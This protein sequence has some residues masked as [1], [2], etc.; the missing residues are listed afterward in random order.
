MS[1][2]IKSII[3]KVLFGTG[4]MFSLCL[5]Q[6]TLAAAQSPLADDSQLAVSANLWGNAGSIAPL[7]RAFDAKMAPLASSKPTAPI[8]FNPEYVTPGGLT[9]GARID[10]GSA[11]QYDTQTALRALVPQGRNRS[12]VDK[13]Y[14]YADGS[15]GRI[16]LG[17]AP[18]IGSQTISYAPLSARITG[19][20]GAGANPALAWAPSLNGKPSIGRSFSAA[21]DFANDSAKVTYFSPRLGGVQFAGAFTPKPDTAGLARAAAALRFSDFDG[22]IN[23]PSRLTNLRPENNIDRA[24][25]VG[26]NYDQFLGPVGVKGSLTYGA[27]HDPLGLIARADTQALS[28]GLNLSLGDFTL[29]GTYGY[30]EGAGL[31]RVFG[32]TDPNANSNLGLKRERTSFDLGGTYAVNEWTLGLNFGYAETRYPATGSNAITRAPV[33]NGTEFSFDYNLA[34]GVDLISA[35]QFINFDAA[36]TDKSANKITTNLLVG[37]QIKF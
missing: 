37:T 9:L 33:S 4:V 30:A 16:S 22:A 7:P 13:Q 26:V 32:S 23:D 3:G 14:I 27:A 35:V 2:T 28:L 24:Y 36:S 34:H 5:S 11:P 25:E 29:G 20:D 10:V 17:Q 8:R 6:R 19:L 18:G 31:G 1:G 21:T 15:F 12:Y